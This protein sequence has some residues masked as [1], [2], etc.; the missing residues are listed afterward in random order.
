MTLA[1]GG[2]RV[3]AAVD[4]WVR[5]RLDTIALA[6]I[7]GIA[8]GLRLW[9][10]DDT[11]QN[12]FY[13]AGV[14]SMLDSWHN[15]FYVSFDP[16]G[17]LAIDKPPLGLWLEAASARAFG[18]HYWALALPQAMAGIAA[19]WVLYAFVR[20]SAGGWAAVLS[21]LFLAIAPVS[22]VT[23]RNNTF[24]TLTMLL[25][26]L[27][28]CSLSAAVRT[29]QRRWLLLSAALLGLG[30]DAKMAEA[31]LPLPA[32]AIYW[33]AGNQLSRARALA[34]AAAFTA[35][36]TVVSFSWITVVGLTPAADRPVIY[37]GEGNNIW[38][39]TFRYNGIDRV[40]GR[41]S[42]ERLRGETGEETFKLLAASV[43]PSRGALRLITSRLANE[44]GWFLPFAGVGLV[45]VVR[46]R[47]R[48]PE[49]VL[50][51]AWLVSGAV[52]FSMAEVAL[53]Q[54]LESITPPLAVLSAI[55]VI[56][57]KRLLATLPVVALGACAAAAA[58]SSWLLLR[59]HGDQQLAVAVLVA[60]VGLVVM[61]T[62]PRWKAES[63]ALSAAG[64][65]AVAVG[66]PWA[67]SLVTVAA[68]A[69][70]SA[71]R[72]PLSGPREVRDYA[73]APGGDQPGPSDEDA[74]LRFLQANTS[75]TRYLVL[76]E[77]ALFGNSARYILQTNRPVLTLDTFAGDESDATDTISRL[78]SSGELRYAE[79]PS[80][81]PWDDPLRPLGAWF[82]GH[83]EDLTPQGIVPLGGESRLFDCRP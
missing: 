30:F 29:G 50:W 15:F 82:T 28:A 55:G 27:A 54:Y 6:A 41:Q 48:E 79:L 60:G 44:V 52:Y 65:L 83:C 10:L 9:E 68:P 58:Y 77:R 61:A 38:A 33:L 78:V 37:N 75:G 35:V 70:G 46:R 62:L 26:L 42:Q 47:F 69:T 4:T 80:G 51:S 64:L 45:A 5:A 17:S 7:L 36:L 81:G 18:F 76:T 43:P 73:E 49:D 34:H 12:L 57:L 71:T 72:Y 74:A 25:T 56:E 24:D 16:G 1:A 67:W 31:L 22:V 39:L 19:T 59:N 14:R 3:H 20:R 53:P 40:L 11:G 8:A 66:G 63:R 21:A 23:S 32:F 13:A 2:H